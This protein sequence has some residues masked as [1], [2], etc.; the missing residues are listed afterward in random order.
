MRGLRRTRFNL[1][2]R[3]APS[4]AFH[5][6]MPDFKTNGLQFSTHLMIPKAQD[7][8]AFRF[9]KEIPFNIVLAL[10]WKSMTTAIQL[11][12]QLGFDAMEIEKVN[13]TRRLAA[14]LETFKLAAAQQS[15]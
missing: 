2:N 8:N 3:L 9:Q 10:I 6:R 11:D 4:G 14:E 15:P 7:L 1:L 5:Q 13:P 12:G